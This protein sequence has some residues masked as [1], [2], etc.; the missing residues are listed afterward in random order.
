MNLQNSDKQIHVTVQSIDNEDRIDYQYYDPKYFETIDHLKEISQVSSAEL[1]PLKQLLVDGEHSLTGGATPLGAAYLTDGVPFIRVQNVRRTGI[2]SS[3]IVFIAKQ[4]HDGE[5]KRS[6]LMPK[7]VLLTITG[8]TYGISAVVP[9]NIEIANINQHVVKIRVKQDEILPE[10]LALYLNSKYGRAQ[11]D[12]NV[13]GG[14][15]PALDYTTIRRLLILRPKLSVQETIVKAVQKL[16]EEA[17]IMKKQI[18]QLEASFDGIVLAKLN[19]Q[20]PLEPKVKVF[21]SQIQEQDRLEVKWFYPYYDEVVKTIRTNKSRRLADYNHELK[22]GASIDADYVSDIPFLR[23][24]NLRR[25]YLDT[26][27]LQFVPSSVYRTEISGLYLHDGDVLVERSGTY[28]GLCSFVPK[29]MDTFVYGSYIIRLRLDDPRILP[30]YI[31]VYINSIL[32]RTQFDRLKT[33][34]LQFNIN[35]QHI[36]NLWIIEPEKSLQKEIASEVFALV[37]RATLLKEQYSQKLKQAED[38]FM[39]MLATI[40]PPQIT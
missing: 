36:R 7:D 24:E 2:D 10:Y 31:S 18:E 32:G 38:L 22:Y 17:T 39:N 23:I 16:R 25:N 14:S 11:T 5:L 1:V 26:S 37:Q 35:T 9:D 30:E 40:E 21:L 29:N 27:D 20:L 4:I 34:A 15:R 8:V 12:R 28:V 13:T 3:N 33:G 6:Q 19:F